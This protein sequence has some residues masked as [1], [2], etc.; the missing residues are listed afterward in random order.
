MGPQGR[1][2]VAEAGLSQ[3]EVPLRVIPLGKAC[4]GQAAVLLEK[5]NGLKHY[6]K[7]VVP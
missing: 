5:R 7:P 2:A 4:A 6:Y 1:G 3:R